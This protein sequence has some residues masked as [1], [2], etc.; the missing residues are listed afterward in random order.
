V[1]LDSLPLEPRHLPFLLIGS[2][3]EPAVELILFDKLL[4]NPIQLRLQYLG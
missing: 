4:Q 3:A 1:E 2:K